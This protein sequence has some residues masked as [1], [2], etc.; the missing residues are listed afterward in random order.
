M[1]KHPQKAQASEPATKRQRLDKFAAKA[2]ASRLKSSPRPAPKQK[3]KQKHVEIPP[4][5][6]KPEGKGKEKA[7]STDVRPPTPPV[8]SKSKAK[9]KTNTKPKEDT[10]HALPSTFNVIAGSYEK[11]LYGLEGS[12]TVDEESNV[13]FHL[14]PVFIFPAHVSCIKAVAASPEGGKWLAT[15]SADEIIKVWDLRRKKEIGG[16]MHHE[17]SSFPAGISARVGDGRPHRLDNAPELPIA[18]PSSFRLG[19]RHPVFV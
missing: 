18:F 8:K 7:T 1:A 6:V 3:Q 19:G 14:K 4:V 11:L 16:L 12:T 10:P 17:G 13:L 5:S 15:G 2:S 9:S